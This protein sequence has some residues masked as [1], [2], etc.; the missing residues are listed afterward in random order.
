MSR[1]HR[2]RLL[3]AFASVALCTFDTQAA[4]PPEPP[5]YNSQSTS[6]PESGLNGM[7]SSRDAVATRVGLAILQEGG[8]ANDA[9]VSVGFAMA[10]TTPQAGNIGG[11]GFMMVHSGDSGK[12]VAIDYREKAPMKAT[13]DMFLDAEGNVESERSAVYTN[14]RDCPEE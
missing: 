6:H 9:A 14:W 8:N 3:G 5:I 12:T 10:L 2:S 13:R 11:G 7:V 1:I 4:P